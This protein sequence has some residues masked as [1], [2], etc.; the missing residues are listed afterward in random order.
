MLYLKREK[1]ITILT[2]YVLFQVIFNGKLY[3]FLFKCKQIC[4]LKGW[5]VF[6]LSET[7]KPIWIINTFISSCSTII[8]FLEYIGM[9]ILRSIRCRDIRLVY[10]DHTV[11]FPVVSIFY[12]IIKPLFPCI[13]NNSMGLNQVKKWLM[14]K[15]FLKNCFLRFV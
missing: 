8:P 10:S 13:T 4:M 3:N 5:K 11:F 14:D 15:I 2:P 12:R 9:I 7:L 6:V 1:K